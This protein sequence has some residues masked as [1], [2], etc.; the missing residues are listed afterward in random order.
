MSENTEKESPAGKK[1]LSITSDD[2]LRYIGFDVGPSKIGEFFKS[3]LEEEKLVEHVRDKRQQH[4]VFRDTSNFRE[5]RVSENERW[6]IVGACAIVIL[7]FFLPFTPMIGGYVETVTEVAAVDDT[8]V[9][10][11]DIAL[12][13]AEA[14]GDSAAAAIG[15]DGDVTGTE[16]E[17]GTEAQA[18]QSPPAN[19]SP[20][21][22]QQLAVASTKT[23]VEKLPYSWSSLELITNI[24][25]YSGALF[26]SGIAVIVSAIL[27]GL[28]MLMTLV[29][30]GYIIAQALTLKGDP[31]TVA[32]KL[33]D[34]LRLAW[35]PMLLF[36]GLI[37]LSMVGGDY[38]F[39]TS[40]A[41][42]QLGESYS[43]GSLLGLLNVGFFVA[44]AGFLLAGAKSVE[45]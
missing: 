41:L 23:K 22:F 44:F 12:G 28:Y 37:A 9:P 14:L 24:G 31:D 34:S 38:G 17:T 15:G 32:L 8:A 4:D 5:E 13:D 33:K 45:I 36:V 1:T 40:G 26:S 11:D 7:S 43:I 30:P 10:T 25:S 2:R 42:K 29:I 18:E 39:D 21:G 20:S 19:A 35:I 3:K 27:M 16:T 6:T